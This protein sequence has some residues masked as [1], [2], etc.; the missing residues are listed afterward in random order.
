LR[1]RAGVE[2]WFDCSILH[3]HFLAFPTAGDSNAPRGGF[4]SDRAPNIEKLLFQP[5]NR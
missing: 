5:P 2:R 4:A 3:G 1:I